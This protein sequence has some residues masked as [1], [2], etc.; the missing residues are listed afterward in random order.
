MQVGTV[1]F[2]GSP[3][4]PTSACDRMELQTFSD[5]AVGVMLRVSQGRDDMRTP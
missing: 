1:R 2:T 5:G 4:P 3:R